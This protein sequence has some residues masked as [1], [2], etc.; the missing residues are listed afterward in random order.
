MLTLFPGLG[1]R[2]HESVA[3]GHAAVNLLSHVD[4]G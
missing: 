4:L 1:C 3:A 2:L